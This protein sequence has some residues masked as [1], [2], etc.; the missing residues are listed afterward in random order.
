MK[1]S[2]KH[3]IRKRG[4]NLLLF[5][6]LFLLALLVQLSF[7]MN[8]ASIDFKETMQKILDTRLVITHPYNI[9]RF[10]YHTKEEIFHDLET[11]EAM[12]RD[13]DRDPRVI[14]ILVEDYYNDPYF[15]TVAKPDNDEEMEAFLSFVHTSNRPKFDEKGKILTRVELPIVIFDSPESEIL[16]YVDSVEE[17]PYKN[18]ASIRLALEHKDAE[19]SFRAYPV[20]LS[21]LP[22][23]AAKSISPTFVAI[24]DEELSFLDLD[25]ADIVKGRMLNKEDDLGKHARM[26]AP[27]NS[28]FV[29]KD[30]LRY[31]EVGDQVPVS[32][33]YF[34]DI[35]YTKYFEVVGLH[36]AGDM[37]PIFLD[38][39]TQSE[40]LIRHLWIPKSVFDDLLQKLDGYK[41]SGNWPDLSRTPIEGD[42]LLDPRPYS[43]YQTITYP[44]VYTS[45]FTDLSM[46]A[47]KISIYLET[48]NRQYGHEIYAYQSSYDSYKDVA[49]I[50]D[51]S[52]QF[53]K[54]MSLLS[55]ISSILL[56]FLT[57]TFQI[58]KRTK[59]AAI[60][61]VLGWKKIDVH[62]TYFMEYTFLGFVAF[63]LASLASLGSYFLSSN[64]KIYFTSFANLEG[65]QG[66][67]LENT[68][69][70]IQRY[71][72]GYNWLITLQLF[73]LWILVLIFAI[74]F[75]VFMQRKKS[76]QSLFRE[77]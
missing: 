1:L 11:F 74:F 73:L 20:D 48:M 26:I 61:E 44:V 36:N 65:L 71:Q 7:V 30:G 66:K 29:T 39:R 22:K 33:N 14:K 12:I 2:W 23:E 59:E 37:V 49:S 60:L 70:A 55:S 54:L 6:L 69:E 63:M 46:I 41:K 3:L 31:V 35:K 38:G 17:L 15:V 45:N 4:T 67:I 53:F 19:I 77:E 21:T 43:G 51:S 62:K 16:G 10:T 72:Q 34:G 76:L 5:F 28:V 57:F 47:K 64:L 58:S 25:R 24:Q 32:I 68:V 42:I 52:S 9:K 50:V 40:S 56:V 18:L 75:A 8:D 27:N 13:L